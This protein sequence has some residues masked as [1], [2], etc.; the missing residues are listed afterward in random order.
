MTIHS[1]Y[2]QACRKGLFWVRTQITLLTQRC[3]EPSLPRSILDMQKYTWELQMRKNK[4]IYHSE[5]PPT[6]NCW[7]K[8]DMFYLLAYYIWQFHSS[9][10]VPV[11]EHCFVTHYFNRCRLFLCSLIVNTNSTTVWRLCCLVS[12]SSATWSP[13]VRSSTISKSIKSMLLPP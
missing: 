9:E 1:V 3:F 5:K 11:C 10:P 6:W 7:N 12:P 13:S 8:N 4:P 2:S